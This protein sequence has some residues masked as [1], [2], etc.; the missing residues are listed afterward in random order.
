M[1]I[2]VQPAHLVL[3]FIMMCLVRKFRKRIETVEDRLKNVLTENASLLIFANLFN[4][5]ML[6][7]VSRDFAGVLDFLGNANNMAVL[8]PNIIVEKMTFVSSSL[9]VVKLHARL[10]RDAFMEDVSSYA[11]MF[12][13]LKIPTVRMAI[14][15]IFKK[16]ASLML[17]VHRDQ[18]VIS[19]NVLTLAQSSN[20]FLMNIVKMEN[21]LLALIHVRILSALLVNVMTVS[22][23]WTLVQEFHASHLNLVKRENVFVVF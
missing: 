20:V 3:S 14:A 8:L 15:I 1:I 19:E 10:M 11:I 17:N 13:V 5:L 2:S 9:L 6:Q 4:V 7:S 23:R 21:V 18:F 16:A 12:F 22:A